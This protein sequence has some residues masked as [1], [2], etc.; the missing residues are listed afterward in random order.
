MN[1]MFDDVRARSGSFH[2]RGAIRAADRRARMGLILLAALAWPAAA[3][4]PPAIVIEAGARL[5]RA[6][7][8]AGG[9]PGQGRY[10]MMQDFT[11]DGLADY[12]V[13]EGNHA[14]DGRGNPFIE[15]GQA[16][17]DIYV[18]DQ[19]G[20]AALAYRERLLAVRVLDSDP[21]SVQVAQRGAGC[22][23]RST[24]TTE[25]GGTLRWNA[26]AAGFDLELTGIRADPRARMQRPAAGTIIAQAGHLK[27][28]TQTHMPDRGEGSAK[29]TAPVTKKFPA[30]LFRSGFYVVDGTSCADASNAT[31]F[32]LGRAWYAGDIN[33]IR[34]KDAR[35]FE[36]NATSFF[37]G[38]VFETHGFLR[39]EAPTRIAMW[40]ADAPDA[41]RYMN[42]C[43]RQ[44][45]SEWFRD[46]DISSIDG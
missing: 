22:G 43:P 15:D 16:H 28:A 27:G 9:T 39:V 1:A 40:E 18:A 35:L 5:D 10:L 26:R 33:W 31:V 44:Q 20:G 19:D 11:G 46:N 6:C 3:Q 2:V 17:V 42:H 36:V 25:C 37:H 7:E 8:A 34:Q 13:N 32:L 29:S 12:L 21:P 24:A 38:D 14:C 23:P 45:L 41:I 4:R 30:N